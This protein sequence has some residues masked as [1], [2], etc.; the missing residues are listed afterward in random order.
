MID[1]GRNLV[2]AGHRAFE[3]GGIQKIL[4]AVRYVRLGMIGEENR[5]EPGKPSNRTGY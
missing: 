1:D 4:E 2:V 3:L 5:N